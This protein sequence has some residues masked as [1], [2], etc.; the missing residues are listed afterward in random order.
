MQEL[1]GLEACTVQDSII[2]LYETHIS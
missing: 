2:P 1:F